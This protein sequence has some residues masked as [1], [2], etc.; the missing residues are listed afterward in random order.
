MPPNLFVNGI[1][2]RTGSVPGISQGQTNER[3]TTG[4]APGD[5]YIDDQAGIIYR[6]SG[7]AWVAIISSGAG[8]I[9]GGPLSPLTMPVATGAQTIGDGNIIQDVAGNIR[10]P[11]SISIGALFADSNSVADFNST[12]QGIR[13]PRMT[14]AERAAIVVPPATDGLLVYCTNAPV[15]FYY[16]QAGVGWVR[17]AGPSVLGGPFTPNTYPVADPVDPQKLVDG[18]IL[19]SGSDIAI[20]GTLQVGSFAIVPGSVAFSVNT[21]TKGM[22]MPRMTNGQRAA[23]A[24]PSMGLM[25]FCT[26]APVGLYYYNLSSAAWVYMG[27]GLTIGQAVTGGNINTVLFEDAA[28]NLGSST[29]LQWNG[30]TLKPKHLSGSGAAPTV[31]ALAGAGGAGVVTG[32]AGTDIAGVISLTPGLVPG[33]GAPVLSVN[34][35]TNYAAPPN[36]VMVMPANAAAY[37][38]G[39]ANGVYVVQGAVTPAAFILQLDLA[40]VLIAGTLYRWYYLVIE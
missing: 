30:L 24:A 27:P 15:G 12:T 36:C 29:D 3:P 20:P 5:L 31:T 16:Y 40:G 10:T 9:G 1:I 2:N 28:G 4:S 19:E 14:N 32:L 33:I 8:T 7:S 35:A 26:D 21:T 13:V 34:F 38:L 39:I 25:V 37:Q 6:W 11:L 22:R 18:H 23:I 17:L